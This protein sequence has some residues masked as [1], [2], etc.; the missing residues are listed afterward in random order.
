MAN[1]AYVCG[2]FTIVLNEKHGHKNILGLGRFHKE[3]YETYSC[4][5]ISYIKSIVTEFKDYEDIDHIIPL[6]KISKE[7]YTQLIEYYF[8]KNMKY[9]AIDVSHKNIPFS[10]PSNW[11]D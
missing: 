1:D 10:K 6:S 7:K 4:N 9:Y 8:T 3:A 5:T 2:L 11:I